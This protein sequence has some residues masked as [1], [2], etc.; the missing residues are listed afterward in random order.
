ME[1]VLII[2]GCGYIGSRLYQFLTQQG[3]DVISVDLEWFGKMSSFANLQDD[4]KNLPEEFLKQFHTIILL[5]GHSS[6][7]M[8][9][10]N[11]TSCFN[12]NVVNFLHLLAKIKK[13]QKFI[14]AS[15]SSIYGSLSGE[16]ISEDTCKYRA[17]NYYDLSKYS[18]DSYAQLSSDVEYYGL[19]FG[20]VNGFSLNF[21]HDIMI[22]AMY[23][24]SKKEGVVRIN[25]PNIHRPILGLDDL[26]RAVY[27]IIRSGT[28]EKKG[29]Y[30]LASFNSKVKDIGAEVADYMGAFLEITP[31]SPNVYDF[32]I[33]SN[34]FCDKFDFKFQ[35]TARTILDEISRGDAHLTYTNRN[36]PIKYGI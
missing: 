27:Q 15:S 4:F 13:H 21:R 10:N 14:Y 9:L 35:N 20:T 7:K 2:G 25:N 23:Y 17:I 26:C 11:L 19:R 36:S 24:S 18:I 28:P 31:D 30:N 34:L 12:N 33:S 1:K 3:I 29:V 8:C 32:T 6:V 16:L 5:A 22:N